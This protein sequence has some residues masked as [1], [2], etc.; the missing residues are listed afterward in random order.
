MSTTFTTHKSNMLKTKAKMLTEKTFVCAKNKEEL[1]YFYPKQVMSLSLIVAAV[2]LSLGIRVRGKRRYLKNLRLV[3][4]NSMLTQP[5]L[6]AQSKHAI[7]VP[8]LI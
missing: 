7:Y 1:D 2:R 4:M 3:L 8:H 5:P 6:I